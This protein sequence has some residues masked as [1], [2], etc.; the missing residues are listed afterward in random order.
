[1]FSRENSKIRVDITT[2]YVIVKSIERINQREYAIWLAIATKP[3]NN[4]NALTMLQSV[5]A[6]VTPTIST[7]EQKYAMVT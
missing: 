6:S 2:K 1:M 7:V 3:S 4:K 5:V